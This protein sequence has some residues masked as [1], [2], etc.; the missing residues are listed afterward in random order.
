MNFKTTEAQFIQFQQAVKKYCIFFGL[1][2][3]ECHFRH[4]D[5]HKDTEAVLEA[6]S[7]S[8][9][10]VFTLKRS[11]WTVE[12]SE[13]DIDKAAF[14]E[15]CELLLQEIRENLEARKPTRDTDDLLHVVI[16]QL[17]NSVWERLKSDT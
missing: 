17:E 2:S 7:G 16:R 9:N 10:A 12:P 14:H 4:N 13:L 1:L 11:G 6:E 15:V 3:F 8:R 5:K